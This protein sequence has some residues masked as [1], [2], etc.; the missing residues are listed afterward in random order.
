MAEKFGFD[1]KLMHLGEKFIDIVRNPRYGYGKNMNPCIDCRILM[2][3]EARKF[4]ELSGA[5]FIVTGEVLGQRPKSQFKNG[6]NIVE[7]DSGLKGWL[8][9]P[10][11]AKLLPQTIPEKNGLLDREQL[12]TISG[13]S[14]SRQ[15]ELAE[16]YGLE[17]YPSPAAGCL[18]TD[19]SYSRRLKD[20]FEHNERVD[21]NDVNLLRAGRHFRLS[22]H[23]KVIVGRNKEDNGKLLKYAKAE[24]T[25]LE[26]LGTGSPITLYI[27]NRGADY[28]EKAAAITAR[29][30]DLKNE[31]SVEVTCRYKDS[32]KI[33]RVSPAKLDEISE[34]IIR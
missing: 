26:A 33:L 23:T 21:F 34:L 30:S 12:E 2:L 6:L 15:M 8:V 20:L 27:D 16:E 1:V 32:D 10:L 3:Q 19:A 28:I 22:D 29:Y 25:V 31:A 5:D 18:L 24:H 7:R 9:R 11:S 17:D 14:R 13:R 4:M